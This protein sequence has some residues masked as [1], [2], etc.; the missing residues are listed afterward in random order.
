M[1]RPWMPLYVQDFQMD[2]LDLTAEQVGAYLLLLMLAW[3]R[4]GD[5]PADMK[6]LKTVF[7][8]LCADMHG[9][10]FNALVPPILERYF[11]LGPD[12]K[13]RNKRLCQEL[14]KAA[15][16]AR[17]QSDNAKKRWSQFRVINNL[18]EPGQCLSQSH[19]DSLKRL[20]ERLKKKE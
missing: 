9:N 8:R 7:K 12:L 18:Q 6:W 19:I 4:N 1:K 13:Y 20:S 5:I 14:E 11:I 15:I 16:F 3:K 17:N 2:T 10:K